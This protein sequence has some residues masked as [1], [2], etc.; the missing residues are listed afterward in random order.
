VVENDRLKL[1]LEREALLKRA[2][3][4]QRAALDESLALQAALEEAIRAE[5]GDAPEGVA[6]TRRAS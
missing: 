5:R 3:A 2:I 1:L 4:H 6:Q